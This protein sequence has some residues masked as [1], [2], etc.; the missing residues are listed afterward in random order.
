MFLTNR[1][2]Q[3]K[4]RE[5][6]SVDVYAG[7]NLYEA[8]MCDF[9]NFC[10]TNQ[11][12]RQCFALSNNMPSY[13]L[14]RNQLLFK[15][16][17]NW[18]PEFEVS[19]DLRFVKFD[20]ST[21]FSVI[22]VTIGGNIGRIGDRIPAVWTRRGALNSLHVSTAIGANGDFVNY[23]NGIAENKWINLTIRQYKTGVCD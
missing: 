6:E 14:A 9:R 12:R 7:D 10:I 21:Y 4:P 22:H 8:A 5:I 11:G 23:V 2:N 3:T 18:G 15:D 13:A 16:V 1:T 20:S 17:K 19:T